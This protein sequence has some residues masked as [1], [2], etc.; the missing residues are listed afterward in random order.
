[1]LSGWRGMLF[2]ALAASIFWWAVGYSPDN[3]YN[4]YAHQQT[5]QFF[6]DVS[7]TNGLLV[8]FTAVLAGVAVLTYFTLKEQADIMAGTLKQMGEDTQLARAQLRASL[9]L[10]GICFQKDP[11]NPDGRWAIV[12]Q[13]RNFG[14]TPARIIGAK[15]EK[16]IGPRKDDSSVFVLSANADETAAGYRLASD[17]FH[18]LRIECNEIGGG[19]DGWNGARRVRAMAY[20]WGRIEYT[21]IFDEAWYIAFQAMGDFGEIATMELC[22]VGNDAGRLKNG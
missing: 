18:T 17:A 9:E 8:V 20:V 12:L 2:A 7:S 4:Q 22:R 1:M 10:E 21:D 6:A 19:I 5:L 15:I 16:H 3:Q 14:Q 13:L 11:Q